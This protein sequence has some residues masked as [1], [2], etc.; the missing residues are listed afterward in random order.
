MVAERNPTICRRHRGPAEASLHMGQIP[1]P[2]WSRM[3][4]QEAGAQHGSERKLNNGVDWPSA[5]L[6]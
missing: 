2:V 4:A 1:D 6:F 5:S 3:Q